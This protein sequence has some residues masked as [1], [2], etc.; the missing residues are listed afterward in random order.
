MKLIVAF[1]FFIAFSGNTVHESIPGNAD[2]IDYRGIFGE[3]YT[4]AENYL[5]NQHWISDSLK[6][7]GLFP[8]LAKAI[9]FPEV[10]RYSVIRNKLELHGLFTLYVQYGERYSDFS[11]G[12][13]QMKP[14][15]A[16]QLELDVFTGDSR[17]RFRNVI[18]TADTPA[19]EWQG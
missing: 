6:A 9:V 13:F 10:I 5:I 4:E 14:S 15:F 1:G 18:D 3:K 2:R 12:Y 19:A 17:G 16:R 11:V 7:N 8:D